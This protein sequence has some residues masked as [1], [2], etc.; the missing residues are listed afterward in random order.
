MATIDLGP[1]STPADE[2]TTDTWQGVARRVGL[3]IPELTH[4]CGL[5]D[6]PL[7]F[8]VVSSTPASGLEGRLG[9]TRSSEEAEAY[10]AAVEALGDPAAS[11]DRRGLL[12]DGELDAGIAG[13]LGVLATPEVA[14]DIDVTIGDLRGHSW[15]RQKDE[16]VAALS[17]VDGLVFEL[18]WFPTAA[19]AAEIDRSAALPEDCELR[20]SQVP[21]HLEVPYQLADAVLEALRSGRSDLVP[22]LTGGD[23]TITSV[24][25]ALA[26]ETRGRLRAMVAAVSPE[27]ASPIGVVS[28]TLVSDGWRTFRPRT[29]DGELQ[30][31]V[32]SV[33]PAD[34]ARDLAPVLA[35]VAK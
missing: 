20:T 13:A 6:A 28:W 1:G 30:L 26:T 29:L 11:L 2:S 19:W 24:L 25:T 16:A 32:T 31:V 22:V 7:P 27:A 9:A 14:L 33:E 8:E 5:I 3:T 4:A 12:V 18:S 21:D 23:A 17:T 35:E 15:H 34:L 10:A